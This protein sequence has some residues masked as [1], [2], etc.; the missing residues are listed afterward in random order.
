MHKIIKGL[1]LTALVSVG[2]CLSNNLAYAGQIEDNFNGFNNN[3]PMT[4][5]NYCKSWPA[6]QLMQDGDYLYYATTATNGSSICFRTIGMSITYKGQTTNIGI[7]DSNARSIDVNGCNARINR[8]AINDIPG[9][10]EDFSKG[11][12]CSVVANTVVSGVINNNVQGSIEGGQLNNC[13]DNGAGIKQWFLNNGVKLNQNMDS[14]FNRYITLK[15]KKEEAPTTSPINVRFNGAYSTLRSEDDED[16]DSTY[17]SCYWKSGDSD[18]VWVK[19]GQNVN[20]QFTGAQE[21]YGIKYPKLNESEYNKYNNISRI[22]LS[23]TPSTRSGDTGTTIINNLANSGDPNFGNSAQ[24]SNGIFGDSI[25]IK[26]PHLASWCGQIDSDDTAFISDTV[27]PSYDN[28]RKNYN[29]LLTDTTL[30]FETVDKPYWFY[31]NTISNNGNQAGNAYKVTALGDNKGPEFKIDYGQ[32]PDEGFIGSNTFTIKDIVD[33]CSDDKI[34][35]GCGVN[36]ISYKTYAE[37]D[38]PSKYKYSIMKSADTYDQIKEADDEQDSIGSFLLSLFGTEEDSNERNDKDRDTIRDR[39]VTVDMNEKKFKGATTVILEI[40]ATD[41]LGNANV[42]QVPLKRISPDPETIVDLTDAVYIDGNDYWFKSSDKAPI[43]VTS[44]VNSKI[45]QYPDKNVLSLKNESTKDK[46]NTF[47]GTLNTFKRTSGKQFE[48]ADYSG[49]NSKK[50]GDKFT[51]NV[52]ISNYK[53][54]CDNTSTGDKFAV[55]AY[56]DVTYLEE[57][58]KSEVS[59]EKDGDKV[60]IDNDSPEL[61]A[62]VCG[63]KSVTFFANDKDSG[64]RV[65]ELHEADGDNVGA[66]VDSCYF[67]TKNNKVTTCTANEK[68]FNNLDEDKDYVLVAY[69][70]V[71]NKSISRVN[72]RPSVDATITTEVNQHS[73]D[74]KYY[75]DVNGQGKILNPV[76]DF[77]GTLTMNGNGYKVNDGSNEMSITQGSSFNYTTYVP[78]DKN[79]TEAPK[80]DYSN[81]HQ[82]TATLSWNKLDDVVE[83]YSFNMTST[84]SEMDYDKD[85]LQAEATADFC[86]GYDGN[87][88]QLYYL[89]DNNPGT[90]T[91]DVSGM[92][93]C[94]SV[95][96]D[97]LSLDM[98]N[99]KTGWYYAEVYMYDK[100]GNPSG[101]GHIMFHHDQ[102]PAQ[103]PIALSVT[104]VKDIN[105][106]TQNYPFVYSDLGDGTSIE[107]SFF[108]GKDNDKFPLGGNYFDPIK[109]GYIVNYRIKR[110]TSDITGIKIDYVFVPSGGTDKDALTME[111][112]NTPLEQYD[113]AEHTNYVSKAISGDEFNNIASPDGLLIKHQIPSGTVAYYKGT[114]NQYN[115]NVDVLAKFSVTVNGNVLPSKSIRLYTINMA[116]T[117]EDDVKIDIRR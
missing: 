10:K 96:S 112:N 42:V 88:L 55:N 101:V 24:C 53:L 76:P 49:A 113:I 22:K 48:V 45:N 115:G 81:D 14:Y 17:D 66:L 95:H 89:G 94:K 105:W 47:E 65:V 82:T 99:L 80:I 103:I 78:D 85:V 90:D 5:Y 75:L 44:S 33:Y 60:C 51:E 50:I 87:D 41:H 32:N 9:V 8:I 28:N 12:V 29:G 36:E 107:N 79:T 63:S 108:P 83:H 2:I 86:S 71:G 18:I 35:K 43:T 93:A 62:I 74:N 110:Q 21:N 40:K 6:G 23:I 67:S 64:L 15:P 111:Y 116:E 38:D 39:K 69:D 92:K 58:F 106:E 109:N 20:F 52:L 68:I 54:S 98:S 37:G 56:G 117:A 27:N 84:I 7:P 11:K 31:M 13:F 61:G 100:N 1:V 26:A 97:T 72:D 34:Y 73:G 70:N 25:G 30:N 19:P 102:P 104:A 46:E 4:M 57:E 114:S 3:D 91:P 59:A 77:N 16:G